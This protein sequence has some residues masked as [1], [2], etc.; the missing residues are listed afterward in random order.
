MLIYEALKEDHDKL[1]QIFLQ[2]EALDPKADPSE[3]VQSL[4]DLLV[5][6]SRAEEAVFYNSLREFD[7]AKDK[8]RHSYTEHMGAEGMLRLLQVKEKLPLNWKSTVQDLRKAVEHH[9]REEEG[10]IFSLARQFFTEEEATKM[11][12]AFERLKAK[13]AD[14]GMMKNTLDM[15]ANMMPP[16]F[17]QSIREYRAS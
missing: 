15:V 4:R 3:L 6:H 13:S 12:D 11:A 14:E 9:I 10:E 5:P 16:R 1:K 7:R 2:L 17:S 8:I